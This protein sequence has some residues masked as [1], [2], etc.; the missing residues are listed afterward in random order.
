VTDERTRATDQALAALKAHGCRMTPQRRAIVSEIM[1][2]DG[3]IAPAELANRVQRKIPGINPATV[4]RTLGLLDELGILS[5]AH[6]GGGVEYHVARDSDH[7]HL[8]CSNCGTTRSIPTSEI[9]PVITMIRASHGFLPDLT[10]FAIEG[11]CSDCRPRQ[12]DKAKGA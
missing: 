5:H 11:L 6:L 7:V 10:H 2:A 9:E 1:Q 8:I 3:H 12:T 4:Y